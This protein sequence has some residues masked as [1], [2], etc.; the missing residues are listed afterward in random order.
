MF[1]TFFLPKFLRIQKLFTWSSSRVSASPRMV[2]SENSELH[3]T[4]QQSMEVPIENYL[5]NTK[6]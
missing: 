6:A 4:E 2:N 1:E 3:I 5:K